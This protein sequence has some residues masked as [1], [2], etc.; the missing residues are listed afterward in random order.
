MGERAK[1]VDAKHRFPLRIEQDL[2]NEIKALHFNHNVSINCLLADMVEFA[3]KHPVFLNM[4]NEKYP[5]KQRHGHFIYVND[6][7]S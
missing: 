7:R 1:R 3:H 4:I 5:T 2:F 6:W